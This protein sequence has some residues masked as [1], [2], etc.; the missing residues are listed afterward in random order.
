MLD[1]TTEAAHRFLICTPQCKQ[2]G[3]W[4][5][6]RHHNR[7]AGVTLPQTDQDQG[8]DCLLLAGPGLGFEKQLIRVS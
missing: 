6:I 4:E 1:Q 7:M 5:N 8:R 2:E 3:A